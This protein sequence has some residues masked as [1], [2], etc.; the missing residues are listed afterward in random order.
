[1]LKER[2]LIIVFVFFLLIWKDLEYSFFFSLEY[3]GK[4]RKSCHAI[5]FTV[6]ECYRCFMID[7]SSVFLDAGILTDKVRDFCMTNSAVKPLPCFCRRKGKCSAE[8]NFSPGFVHSNSS[9]FE[10]NR[11]KAI[12]F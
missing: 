3:V 4:K 8:G 12:S 11:S 1:M 5:G 10:R 9:I 2:V 6:S 7:P